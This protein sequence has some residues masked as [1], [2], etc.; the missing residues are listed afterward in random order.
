VK[1][2][3][4]D[5]PGMTRDTERRT[6]MTTKSST[7][8]AFALSS[9]AIF[10]T[11]LD[12]LVV[13]TALPVIREDLG[14]SIESLEWT[15]NAYT[16]TFAVLLLTGAALG[17]RFGRRRMFAIGMAIFTAASAAAAL[18][19]SIELLIAARAVQGV[20]GAIVTPLS[21]TILVGAIA[22]EKRGMALGL[23][24]G[25]G[26][27]AVALGPLVGGAVTQGL[28]WQWIFWLNVPFGLAAIPLARTRLAESRGPNGRLDLPGVA[29]ASSGLLGVVLALVRGNGAGW[30]SPETLGSAAFGVAA[31]VAFVLWELRAPAPMLPM[32]FFRSRAFA[33]A[34]AASLA[35][36]FGMFGSV[37]LLVQFLQLV[38]GYSPLQAGLRTLAWTAMP[39]VVA[40]IAGM[41]S[42]RIGGR[43]IMA[44]G[45]AADAVAFAWMAMT[46]SPEQSYAA[47]APAL[48]LAG[49]GTS[50]FFAPVANIVMSS[51]RAEQSGQASGATNAIREIG[52]VLGVAVLAAVFSHR[53]GFESG[54]AFVS[55]YQP[56]LLIGAAVLAA[57]AV[58]ALLIPRRRRAQAPAPVLA[59]KPA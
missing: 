50:S 52:G 15:V 3:L 42:D 58:A 38:L 59:P 22:P 9:I 41:L 13:T 5:P 16:L 21:L 53:G 36:Y 30:T 24:S 6:P 7:L 32:S 37:F 44:F 47:L 55:G 1:R 29:L 35:L 4:N 10:M 57:G 45:L 18:A 43:P 56:A 2:L 26:G 28:S 49:I 46:A 14:G 31:L 11:A 19:P 25:I 34:N 40:P 27:L 23:W 51:V 8:W 12:N 54:D 33:A 39:L 17:D 48:V 20:G